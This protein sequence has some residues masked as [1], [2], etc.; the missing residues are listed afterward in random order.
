MFEV[1][2]VLRLISGTIMVFATSQLAVK[3]KFVGH[4]PHHLSSIQVSNITA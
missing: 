4:L 2:I 1:L 3:K